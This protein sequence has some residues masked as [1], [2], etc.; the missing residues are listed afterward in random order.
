MIWGSYCSPITLEVIDSRDDWF[1]ISFRPCNFPG[2]LPATVDETEAFRQLKQGQFIHNVNMKGW[3]DYVCWN[4]LTVV[5]QD[6]VIG[7]YTLLSPLGLDQC[8]MIC[9]ALHRTTNMH[10]AIKKLSRDKFFECNLVKK[11]RDIFG[12]FF[13]SK[14]FFFALALD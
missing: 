10:V 6:E 8:G 4:F 7:Q 12:C 3:K 5:N 1:V 11:L 2:E 14:F 9:K 13:G